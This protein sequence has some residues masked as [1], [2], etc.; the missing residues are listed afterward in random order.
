MGVFF[1]GNSYWPVEFSQ[2]DSTM[3]IKI[4]I[5]MNGQVWDIKNKNDLL[6]D[7]FLKRDM[8][9]W[10]KLMNYLCKQVTIPHHAME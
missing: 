9:M 2:L 6:E 4:Q 3:Y 7:I 10:K 1:Q 5:L 8:K